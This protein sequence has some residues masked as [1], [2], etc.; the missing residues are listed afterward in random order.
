MLSIQRSISRSPGATRARTRS[1]S[2]LTPVP[3]TVST[4]ASRS[5]ST[6]VEPDPGA[7]GEVADIL[8]AVGVQVQAGRRVLH[9]R[10]RSRYP[11]VSP[12]GSTPCTQS[13]V[14]P[15]VP[16]V[17]G[18]R[19]DVVEREGRGVV[20]GDG[21]QAG[22]REV[23][24]DDHADRLAHGVAA[25]VVS[26]RGEGVEVVAGRLEERD[27]FGVVEGDGVSCRALGQP[28]TPL[29][30]TVPLRALPAS[31]QCF[32]APQSGCAGGGLAA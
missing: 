22:R 15:E 24:V 1:L 13:S 26:G 18:D 32:S 30:P 4:P 31:P 9:V 7:V 6:R 23:A 28:V 25:D 27:P 17:G 14:A 19:A 12:A 3:G 10:A 5:A 11:G 16:G 2:T 8:R 29:A 20:G 21:A